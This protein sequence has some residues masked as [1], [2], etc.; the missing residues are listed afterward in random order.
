MTGVLRQMTDI[1][2]LARLIERSSKIV[3]FTGAGI[4]TESGVPD[5]RSKGG[6]WDRFRPVTIQE[7]LESEEKRAEYWAYKFGFIE[8]LKDAK[9]N[10]GH[11]A[12]VA[13]EK[14][15]RLQGVVTQNIDRLH[16]AAGISPDKVLE[17]HGNSLE[18]VCLEC[19][20]VRPWEEV[21]ERLKKGEKAPLCL[22]CGG[23][24]KPNTISFGQNLDPDVL[25]KAYRWVKNCDLLLAVGSTL[26]VEPAASL[27]VTAKQYGAK[28]VIITLS[29]TPLD[30]FADLKI[31]AKIG[32]TLSS[33][34]A[35]V[36]R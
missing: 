34:V 1:E 12:I 35:A 23:L 5:Y 16:Q 9:P 28:L 32:V 4:S 11:K 20:E 26:I 30:D 25:A 14:M 36:R 17:L 15:D 31:E 3:A 2:K 6:L 10:E 19:H 33:A 7:F 24:L 22:T 21:H 29:S 8:E 18:T 27:P 13:L